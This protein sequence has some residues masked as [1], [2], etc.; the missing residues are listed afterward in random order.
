M[1]AG[2]IKTGDVRGAAALGCSS[3]IVLLEKR[4]NMESH[5][6]TFYVLLGHLAIHHP[7][8]EEFLEALPSEI[9]ADEELAEIFLNCEKII[10][11]F[12]NR[13]KTIDLAPGGVH[14]FRGGLTI[15]Q[16][17]S[18]YSRPI[19]VNILHDVILFRTLL[20]LIP[21][22]GHPDTSNRLVAR[23]I[24]ILT[25]LLDAYQVLMSSL[26]KNTW[27]RVKACLELVVII[28]YWL[29]EETH[30]PNMWEFDIPNREGQ[31]E[32]LLQEHIAELMRDITPEAITLLVGPY[33][34]F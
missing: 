29:A 6:K 33:L 34:D 4:P 32:A 7:Q 13:E 5:S 22:E 18:V 20:G 8:V 9:L 30:F 19:H 15:R 24:S 25:R 21:G 11:A 26:H 16:A 14:R 1:I 31:R 12:L 10:A 27:A 3:A 2:E 28:R 17:A 23:T